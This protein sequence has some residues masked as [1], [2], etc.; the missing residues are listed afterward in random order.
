MLK[1]LN[2]GL[3]LLAL[4]LVSCRNLTDDD[5]YSSEAKKVQEEVKK[6]QEE[7]T[8][9]TLTLRKTDLYYMKDDT[10]KCYTGDCNLYFAQEGDIPYVE[11]AEFIKYYLGSKV[12]VTHEGSVY[13]VARSW[14]SDYY[15]TIDFSDGKVT[16]S[17]LDYYALPEKAVSCND[18]ITNYSSFERK[19]L[20]EIRGSNVSYSVNLKDY[21]IPLK[22]EN[23]LGFIPVNT[24][25][26]LLCNSREFLYNG[27]DAFLDNDKNYK[28]TEYSAKISNP[29]ETTSKEFAEYSYNNLCLMLDMNYGRKEYLGVTKFDT[30]ISA[31]GLKS[32]LSSTNVDTA[33]NALAKL[34]L[35][36]I[37][38]VHTYYQHWTP[39]KGLNPNAEPLRNIPANCLY[40][41]PPNIVENPTAARRS[42]NFSILWYKR[43]ASKD[44]A[45]YGN[46]NNGIMN[47]FIPKNEGGTS[48]TANTIFLCFDNFYSTERY[49]Q[50]Y[51]DTWKFDAIGGKGKNDGVNFYKSTGS[52]GNLAYDESITDI[53]AFVAEVKKGNYG[54]GIQFNNRMDTILLTVVSNYIIRKLYADGNRKLTNV[55]LDLSLNTG[56]ANDDEAFMSSW[57]LG[58]SV[59]GYVNKTTGSKSAVEYRSDVNFDGKFD[60]NDTI[61][62]IE[63]LKRYCITSLVSFSCGNLFPSQIYFSDS[64]KTFGQKS[65]GGTC[66]VVDYITPSGDYVVTSSF[67]QMSTFI[68]GSFVDIDAGIDVDVP[69]AQMD[70][71]EV[72]NRYEFCKKLN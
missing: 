65:G 48:A 5:T 49:E 31:A 34:L 42:E 47:I 39:F 36:N 15:F 57:F 54:Y 51:K 38:D 9:E 28:T 60:A 35:Q 23:N 71:S 26:L 4:T 10:L 1:K 55:V 17:D 30:W 45:W 70:F 24:L 21:N 66:C 56:G 27:K 50:D 59:C 40:F 68:N 20:V 53:D 46:E 44:S 12:P 67:T 19:T 7:V 41:T 63:G 58:K 37:A 14:N 69:I 6:V 32:E 22:Y 29:K 16:Y 43:M 11:I 2:A 25:L 3:I 8:A 62:T 64:V 72:Y 13:K 33:E 18:I 52:G 61:A